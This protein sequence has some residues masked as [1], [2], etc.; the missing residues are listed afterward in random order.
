MATEHLQGSTRVVRFPRNA[1]LE[2]TFY[3]LPAGGGAGGRS[4]G[5]KASPCCFCGW[6]AT[7][8]RSAAF[9][10]MALRRAARNSRDSSLRAF[11]PILFPPRRV[12]GVKDASKDGTKI[13]PLNAPC[14]VL[15][16]TKNKVSSRSQMLRPHE[17]TKP[18]RKSLEEDAEVLPHA[19]LV[20]VQNGSRH[21]PISDDRLV[22]VDHRL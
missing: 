10:I 1:R 22:V 21:A 16:D 20:F 8:L 5:K 19:D 4:G 14:Q 18:R 15:S 7:F 17:E 12:L 11:S 2:T 6:A 13:S 3:T 9:S